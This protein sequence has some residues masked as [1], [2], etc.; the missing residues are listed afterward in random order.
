MA[1]T[2]K[3]VIDRVKTILQERGTGIRWTDSEL[4]GWLNEGYIV[5]ASVRPD[6]FDAMAEIDLVAG[7]KQT[8]PSD[9]RRLL[10]VFTNGNG[11]AVRPID[12]NVL[13]TT[14]RAWQYE[15]QTLD[16]ERAVFDDRLPTQFWVYPPAA[17][18]AKLTLLYAKNTEPHATATLSAIQDDAILTE[19]TYAPALVDYVLSRAFMKDAETGANLSRG[20]AHYQAFAQAIGMKGRGDV[21]MSPNGGGD[22]AQRAG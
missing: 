7:A 6:A 22:D 5:V 1:V 15:T 2:V 14:R 9:A 3:T 4:I 21:Q 17:D 19:E 12:R 20:Q 11:G 10:D 18:G 8:L 13:D 16:I